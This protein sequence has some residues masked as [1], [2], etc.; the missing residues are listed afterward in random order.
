MQVGEG[1]S[2]GNI[3]GG[4]GVRRLILVLLPFEPYAKLRRR[5]GKLPVSRSAGMS[6]VRGKRML[7][8]SVVNG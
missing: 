6:H 2:L 7:D 4:G 3:K 5:T 8:P 1:G